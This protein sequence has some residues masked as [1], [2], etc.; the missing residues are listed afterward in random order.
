[1]SGRGRRDGGTQREGELARPARGE[2]HDRD[3]EQ[4]MRKLYT[5]TVTEIKTRASQRM[6][7]S[8]PCW[9]ARV[10]FWPE[11]VALYLTMLVLGEHTSG[12]IC[13][14]AR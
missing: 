14:R 12:F 1:M 8:N 9:T 11:A 2:I 4:A 13:I 6:E 10:S 3:G 7:T 5:N